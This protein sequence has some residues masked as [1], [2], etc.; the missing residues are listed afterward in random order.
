MLQNIVTKSQ[1]MAMSGDGLVE[2]Q[3][4]RKSVKTVFLKNTLKTIDFIH[5]FFGYS[6]IILKLKKLTAKTALKFN[7]HLLCTNSGIR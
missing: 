5:S 2:V 6:S 4:I 1:M 3:C 7:L